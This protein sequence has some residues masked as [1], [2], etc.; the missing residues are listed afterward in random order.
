MPI[1]SAVS[2]GSRSSAASSSAARWVAT[3]TS[4]V[5]DPSSLDGFSNNVDRLTVGPDCAE[6]AVRRRAVGRALRGPAEISEDFVES[7]RLHGKEA[8]P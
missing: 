8:N 4:P 3:Y 2:S 6:R 1:T 7:I 5:A